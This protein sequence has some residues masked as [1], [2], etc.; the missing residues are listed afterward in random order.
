MLLPE[1]SWV[2]GE[3]SHF[4]SLEHHRENLCFY[5]LLACLRWL[6]ILSLAYKRL[7]QSLMVDLQK[8]P[9]F[10]SSH[11]LKDQVVEL[12]GMLP[13][14]SVPGRGLRSRAEAMELSP[15]S[16]LSLVSCLIS[17]K[18]NTFQTAINFIF[19]KQSNY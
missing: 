12:R 5:N 4:C 11:F 19:E 14:V 1:E 15:Y 3:E 2:A 7:K 8:F 9:L 16:G 10:F 6:K 18:A 17:T 13:L